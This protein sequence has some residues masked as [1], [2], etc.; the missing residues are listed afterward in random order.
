[1]AMF[2]NPAD[3][4][5]NPPESWIIAKVAAGVWQIR[6]GDNVLDSYPTRKRAL[7]DTVSGFYVNLYRKEERWFRGEPVY[8]WKAYA[9]QQPATV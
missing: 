4:A 9:A 8:G 2:A 6:I 3:H 1:M 5:A 7:E